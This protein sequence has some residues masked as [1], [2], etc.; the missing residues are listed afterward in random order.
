M[1]YLPPVIKFKNKNT[2]P[3]PPKWVK[4]KQVFRDKLLYDINTY[5]VKAG[6]ETFKDRLLLIYYSLS[7]IA[8]RNTFMEKFSPKFEGVETEKQYVT[9]LHQ[10]ANEMD[11]RN[12]KDASHFQ[13]QWSDA[14]WKIQREGE[15]EEELFSRLEECHEFAYPGISGEACLRLQLIQ[16][17]VSALSSEK[18]FRHLHKHFWTEIHETSDITA[19]LEEIIIWRG[20]ILIEI[21]T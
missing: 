18:L 7:T 3:E 6:A 20:A 2:I 9:M 14:S 4:G 1:K 5:S 8:Q 13:K 11:P 19:I 10:I 12:R 17:F 15:T 16:H 21:L